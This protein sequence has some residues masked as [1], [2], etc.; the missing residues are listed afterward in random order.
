MRW[1]WLFL[2][3]PSLAAAAELERPTTFSLANGL[4]AVVIEDHR[5]PAV[6]H[7]LW[8]R[9]GSADEPPGKGGVAHFLEH[10]MF[11]GTPHVGSG[12]F[13]K[14][15]ARAGGRDNAFTTADYT[16]YHQ[17]VARERLE[18]VMR[19]EAD[20]M[21]NLV[22]SEE[23]VATERDIVL[24]ERRLRT[25]N[26]P[27]ARLHEQAM[28]ALYLAHPYRLPVIGWEHEIRALN[29]DDAIAFYRRWY[30]P[31]NAVLVVAGDVD[32]GEVR[33]LAEQYY[34]PIPAR[35]LGPR[36][37]PQEPPQIAP[38][39]VTLTDPR[40]RQPA[41]NRYYLAPTASY[42]LRVLAQ[43]LGGSSTSRL[44][45]R[46]VVEQGIAAGTGT[47]YDLPS[48]DATRFGIYATPKPG[49]QELEALEQAVDGV[50][51][52]LLRDGVTAEELE[53]AKAGLVAS[54]IYARDNVPG[55]ARVYG[56]ALATG[57][58]VDDVVAWPQRIEAVSLEQVNAAARE[59]LRPERSVTSRLLPKPQS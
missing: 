5:A 11:K 19:M 2:L 51:T 49:A 52:E 28:A 7:M 55:L 34:G 1:F 41:L 8:Y 24:E 36:F 35:P 21:V 16:G 15:I 12:E 18:M 54:A 50:L 37:R 53:R 26:D 39:R 22:L 43:V 32:P 44:N 46:L 29:R 20:R 31:N 6:T 45:R 48:L 38:R 33:R 17:T 57:R 40:V 23:Q 10:L 58:D 42:P 59:V 27:A 9:V 25:D 3:L 47:W 30:A 56:G 4:S 14:A 13:S